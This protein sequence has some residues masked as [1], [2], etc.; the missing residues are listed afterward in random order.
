MACD[1]SVLV[2][3]AIPSRLEQFFVGVTGRC[4]FSARHGQFPQLR[5]LSMGHDRV[6]GQEGLGHLRAEFRFHVAH[7]T[8]GAFVRCVARHRSTIWK[9]DSVSLPRLMAIAR[10]IAFS[11]SCLLVC[12]LAI[13]PGCPLARVGMYMSLC[14]YV[15][16]IRRVRAGASLRRVARH[17]LEPEELLAFEGCHR[18]PVGSNRVHATELVCGARFL[19]FVIRHQY[20]VVAGNVAN[21]LSS[22]RFH[23]VRSVESEVRLHRAEG[24]RRATRHNFRY[25]LQGSIDPV[26]IALGPRASL[27]PFAGHILAACMCGIQL[28]LGR[29]PGLPV[30]ILGACY[31]VQSR[32]QRLRFGVLYVAW[33]IV[34]RANTC[35]LPAPRWR[36]GASRS[37][38]RRGAL[39]G[40]LRPLWVRTTHN[41]RRRTV[42]QPLLAYAACER[43][44][45]S[46]SVPRRGHHRACTSTWGFPTLELS[47]RLLH[48]AKHYATYDFGYPGSLSLFK[49][50]FCVLPVAGRGGF[51]REPFVGPVDVNVV[52]ADHVVLLRLLDISSLYADD[53]R[54][55]DVTSNVIRTAPKVV[56]LTYLRGRRE[57][58]ATHYWWL[59][60]VFAAGKHYVVFGHLRS[61]G[62]VEAEYVIRLDSRPRPV[63]SFL[64][65]EIVVPLAHTQ[66]TAL[67]PYQGFALA[68]EL[69][70]FTSRKRDLSSLQVTGVFVLLR[71]AHP[72]FVNASEYVVLALNCDDFAFGVSLDTD[73]RH[74]P[75]VSPHAGCRTVANL[76]AA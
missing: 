29:Y 40:F 33:P 38:G 45:Y 11:A 13:P 65:R 54:P 34:S 30:L 31:S 6:E 20:A 32:A 9:F 37:S 64:E 22:P 8:L 26:A 74:G 59:G 36:Y 63:H 5:D 73:N 15:F 21:L 24:A 17:S 28:R 76:N 42:M 72:I 55:I 23:V 43:G 56:R 18:E 50:L 25:R 71:F 39:Y 51:A 58:T 52:N 35:A 12:W 16:M 67:A 66:R 1:A 60:K 7:S 62:G 53:L 61:S 70:R 44:G 49:N 10:R 47:A 41:I 46:Q 2:G 48:P 3:V 69:T 14:V 19:K 57:V 68:D 75:T 4:F 27:R